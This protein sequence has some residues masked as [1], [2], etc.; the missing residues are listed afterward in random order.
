MELVANIWPIVDQQTGIIQRFLFRAYALSAS[1]DE[2]SL[3]L[4]TL[5]R[6]DYRTAEAC[7]IPKKYSLTYENKTIAGAITLSG[8][9]EEMYSI[10]EDTL[11]DYERVF[12]ETLNYGLDQNGNPKRHEPLT[13]PD[14]P[15]FVTTFLRELPNGSLI[16]EL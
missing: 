9:N 8:F 5:A 16:P 15:Y 10:I 6:S 13:F 12:A 4:T 11:K 14:E 3:V 1:D 2:I 7:V